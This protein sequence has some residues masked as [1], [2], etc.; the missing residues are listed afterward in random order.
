MVVGRAEEGEGKRMH[1]GATVPMWRLKVINGCQRNDDLLLP[2]EPQ[3]SLLK[4][5]YTHW[6]DEDE[7][8]HIATDHTEPE[9]TSHDPCDEN[10]TKRS[11]RKKKQLSTARRSVI[12]SRNWLQK[13]PHVALGRHTCLPRAF[14]LRHTC[15]SRLHC[16]VVYVGDA[17]THKQLLS[18]YPSTRRGHAASP[19]CDT[20]T[21][22]D[23]ET[24]EI[25]VKD[26]ST[27]FKGPYYCLIH[28]GSNPL[29]V[30]DRPLLSGESH[31]LCEN[32]VVA[33]L[34]NPFDE[35]GGVLQPLRPEDAARHDDATK[36][37]R[38]PEDMNAIHGN[39]KLE[40]MPTARTL[41]GSTST[42]KTAKAAV[43]LSTSS[44]A[45]EVC[46]RACVFPV[47]VEVNGVRIARYRPQHVPPDVLQRFCKAKTAAAST[48]I[49]AGAAPRRNPPLVVEHER[50]GGSLNHEYGSHNVHED[51]VKIDFV[52]GSKSPVQ[53]AELSVGLAC[54]ARR[55]GDS[56]T[57]PPKYP[58]ENME[59]DQGE[60]GVDIVGDVVSPLQQRLVPSPLRG[61][62]TRV[63]KTPEMKSPLAANSIH[64][65]CGD[66]EEP[67]P[68]PRFTIVPPRLPVYVF[69][70]RSP[71]PV[72]FTRQAHSI[73]RF[74]PRQPKGAKE[75][76]E[77]EGEEEVEEKQHE[78]VDVTDTTARTSRSEM[79]MMEWVQEDPA[80]VTATVPQGR[81]GRVNSLR[82]KRQRRSLFTRTR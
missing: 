68:A 39:S 71:S 15:V 13:I 36:G 42:Q 69:A 12:T 70:R 52:K 53:R 64:A 78:E 67:P 22:N 29:Y 7:E 75:E 81:L 4:S 27:S 6:H 5:F 30:N 16:R 40:M 48:T 9:R 17:A 20:V 21:V 74:Q 43:E 49:S 41:F 73:G 57:P 62:S 77:G 66:E 37:E 59:Q 34:E 50:L 61:G 11:R 33:F 63:S 46:E 80:E 8:R 26:D 38:K 28:F 51:E 79:A 31:R 25:G 2:V 60:E 54:L 18:R 14:R 10:K 35:E 72:E 58:W 47:F 24:T 32:D 45:F 55:N 19:K 23:E 3:S 1:R 65:S 56:F 44:H 76:E 82:R